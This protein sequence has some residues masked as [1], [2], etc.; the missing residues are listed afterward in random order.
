MSVEQVGHAQHD[1]ENPQYL[2]ENRQPAHATQIPYADEESALSGERGA[3]PFFRLLNGDWRFHYAASPMQVPAGF[4]QPAYGVDTWDTLPVPSNWQLHGYGRPNYTNV[5]YPYPVD[6]PHVPQENP[7]GLYRRTF[8]LPAA[9]SGRRIFLTF[10]GVDSAFYVWVNGQRVG[11]SQGAHVPSEFDIGAYVRPGENT[12][13][14]QVFQWSDGSYLEDQDMWRLSGIFRDVYLTATPQVYVRD[15]RIRTPLAADYGNATLQV[16]ATL[17]NV[18]DDAAAQGTTL[19]AKLFDADGAVVVEGVFSLN[20]ELAVNANSVCD[21]QAELSNPRKWTA[22]TPYL[23]TLLL[24]LTDTAG[25]VSEVVSYRVGFRQVEVK[26]QQLWVNGVSIKLKGVDRHDTHPDLGHAVSYE[27]MLKDI[28]LMKQHNINTVRTSHYPND[29]RWYDLCDHFGMYIVDEADLEC[30]GFAFTGHLNRISDDPVWEAAYVD[31]AVR[32]VERD[33]NHPCVIIWSLG[34]ESGYGRNHDAMAAWIRA[35]DPT[36][37]I[38]YEGAFDAPLVDIVSVM[39]PKVDW[40]IEQGQK[41]DDPRPFF[42]C[43]YAHAM[44]NGPGNLK[45][46]WEAIYAHPRL[47]GGCIW[48]W[49]DH[50]IRRHTAEGE[51]WFAYGGDFDDYPNDGN[52]CIDGLNFPDRIPHSGLSEYKKVIEPVKVEAVDLRAGRV[53]VQNRY[54]FLSLAHLDVMWTITCDGDVVA[55]GVL[56]PLDVPPGETREIQLPY[57]LPQPKPGATYWLNLS[58]TQAQT[59]LW[60]SR[61]FEV[62][63]AQFELPVEKLAAPTLMLN[64]MPA[65]RT[66][67]A[68]QALTVAGDDFRLVFDTWRGTLE[69]W[70]SHGM[71]L[72]LDSPLAGPRLNVWRAPTDNDVHI[73]KEWVRVGYDHLQQRVS[74]VAVVQRHPQAVQIEVQAVLAPYALAPAFHCT[75]RYTLYGSGDVVIETHVMP[76]AEARL[77]V[78]PRLGLQ[79]CLPGG[80][81]RMA[82][83]GRGPHES[84]IDRKESARVGVYRGTVQEQYVPYIRPQENGNKSDVRWAALT[85]NRGAGLLAVGLPLINV[86]AHHYTTEDLTRAQ[87]TY[88]LKRRNETILN[89]DIEQNGLGS[90]S[91]GP[92]PLE[93]YLLQPIERTFSVRLRPFSGDVSETMRQAQGVLETLAW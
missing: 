17:F 58:F 91:C 15:A 3:S 72:L 39:Y 52:F 75:Y 28:T 40:L 64:Q 62:A 81:D 73:A 43:E 71:A 82:W 33:K 29:P 56:A 63:W 59:T 21:W 16:Q 86:S 70:E 92:A 35:H 69:S 19:K 76:D 83:Y 38:H 89:L 74:N 36:R 49:V 13:A 45:E 27:S 88:E 50:S 90:N 18:A 41:T 85:N 48:E 66:N 22:E 9:W 60:A 42:M 10:E 8:D 84:Y 87:H 51:E 1:W 31:R 34:N 25:Q 55:Q 79:M 47:I 68:G 26:D 23:Y 20:S 78:L 61:G 80:L 14:V 24:T 5:A 57:K 32:M 65:L 2:A 77:P 7:V 44:G 37:L 67:E 12:L 53:R 4:E 30:H 11:Y 54:N 46:Y 6:P 93:K